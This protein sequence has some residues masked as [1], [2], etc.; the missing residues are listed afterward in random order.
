MDES[1][2]YRNYCSTAE[3][4]MSVLGRV[5]SARRTIEKARHLGEVIRAHVNELNH[6]TADPVARWAP[7]MARML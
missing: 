2:D 3:T 6:V 1:K 7:R 4:A 5:E